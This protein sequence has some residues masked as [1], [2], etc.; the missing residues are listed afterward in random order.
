M[1]KKACWKSFQSRKK[2]FKSQGI[3]F[4]YWP[5][6]HSKK[7]QPVSFQNASFAK[8]AEVVIFFP[9]KLWMN[10]NY[11]TSGGTVKQQTSAILNPKT[12]EWN[13]TKLWIIPGRRLK[14]LCCVYLFLD[15]LCHLKYGFFSSGSM[16]CGEIYGFHLLTP[17]LMLKNLS[18]K[19][20]G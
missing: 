14:D 19:A 13:Y 20:D 11:P 7:Y 12:H 2:I 15:F 8:E 1:I 6:T 10:Y 18:F 17:M 3:F 9:T 16:F 4:L 5:E